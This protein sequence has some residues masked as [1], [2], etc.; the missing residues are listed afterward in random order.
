MPLPS[1]LLR[2][3]LDNNK[4]VQEAG[5]SAFATLEE[6]AGAELAPYLE[7]VLR[8]L[9]FAFDKYQHK[10]MLI[11]YDAVGTLADAV[12]PAL[13]NPMY[14]DILMPP[15]NKKWSKLKDDDE[16]LIPLLEV[17][18]ML[19]NDGQQHLTPFH[20]QCLASV[21]IAMGSA[22]LPYSGP[23]F[24]RCVNIA[25]T[26]IVQYQTWHQNPELDEPDKTFL[27]VALDLLSGL[28]QGL[29]MGLKPFI[30][31]SQPAFFQLLVLCLK[32]PQAPV[33]QSAYALV[34]DLAM[35]CFPLLRQHMPQVMH[36]LILQ[37]DPEPKVEFISACNNAAWS[38]GE[39]ALRYGRGR[40]SVKRGISPC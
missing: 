22:F 28:T 31:S 4:R 21:T 5:C 7:P 3:V 38:V 11:L 17:R 13:Q 26:S 27:V 24:E 32:H 12:G 39:V 33:R 20:F 37:L 16:D 30:E 25:R 2:M 9:V 18:R 14:V 40:Y 8:N 1:Q 23:V 6:D 10:N 15:L 35:A 34:G 29:G 19:S 36:E